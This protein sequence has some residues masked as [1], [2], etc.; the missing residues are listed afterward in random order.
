MMRLAFMDFAA[1][2]CLL[3]LVIL[4]G[5]GLTSMVASIYLGKKILFAATADDCEL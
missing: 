3:V 1:S 4:P 2:C 5:G